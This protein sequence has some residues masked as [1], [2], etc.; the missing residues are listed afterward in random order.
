MF[1]VCPTISPKLPSKS[2]RP[3]KFI[4]A[5]PEPARRAGAQAK[6]LQLVR[7]EG[8]RMIGLEVEV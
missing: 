8:T 5:K 4:L 7:S 6:G 1:S 2:Q 3:Q